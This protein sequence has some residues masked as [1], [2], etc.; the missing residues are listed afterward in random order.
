MRAW[1]PWCTASNLMLPRAAN[2]TTQSLALKAIGLVHQNLPKVM[3]EPKDVEARGNMLMASNLAGMAFALSYLGLS[4]SLANALTKMKG[5]PHGL[6]VGMMLP[7]VIRFNAPVVGADYEHIA[8]YVFGRS[9]P[10][11]PPEG[12]PGPGRGGGADGPLPGHARQPERVG[13]RKEPNP[14]SGGGGPAPSHHP[15]QPAHAHGLRSW[16][17]CWNPAFNKP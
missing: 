6:A 10:R 13:I 3:A 5:T 2:P 1:T 16:L 11:R 17:H 12:L 14:C 7:A 9:L 15:V 8:R 4:H